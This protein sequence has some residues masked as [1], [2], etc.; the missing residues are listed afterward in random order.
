[1]QS[2]PL[3]FFASNLSKQEHRQEREKKK[4]GRSLNIVIPRKREKQNVIVHMD[5]KEGDKGKINVCIVSKGKSPPP[6][7]PKENGFQDSVLNGVAGG[8]LFFF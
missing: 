6:L 7:L 1:M 2:S 4:F 5:I 3:I 8:V